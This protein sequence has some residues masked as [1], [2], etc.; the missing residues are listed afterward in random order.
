E[1]LPGTL[2]AAGVQLPSP[3]DFSID[4][5]YKGKLPLGYAFRYFSEAEARKLWSGLH[6]QGL[7]N[8]RA[9]DAETNNYRVTEEVLAAYAMATTWFDWGNI[10]AGVRVESVD[11]T[12]EALVQYDSGFEPVRV[13][14][15]DTVVLP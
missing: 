6:G 10:V 8:V 15:S 4:R 9:G 14:G 2:T 7:S 3:S 11:N 12:G 5:P 1:I 13:S